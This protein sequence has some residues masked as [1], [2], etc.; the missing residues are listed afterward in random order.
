M[1]THKGHLDEEGYV[2]QI[3]VKQLCVQGVVKNVIKLKCD[4]SVGV[5]VG[6]FIIFEDDRNNGDVPL[7]RSFL[8]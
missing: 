6:A 7:L 4:K 2:E 5:N 8:R 3:R 1:V